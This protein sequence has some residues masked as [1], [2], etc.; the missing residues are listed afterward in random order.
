M[1]VGAPK[2]VVPGERRVALVPE[3]VTKFRQAGVDNELYYN[4]KWMMLFGDARD[5]LSK[6]FTAL[7]S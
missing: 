1:V 6:L 5:S 7:K 3:L 4:P 2:E